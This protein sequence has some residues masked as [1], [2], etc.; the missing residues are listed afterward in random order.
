MA[1]YGFHDAAR[2][3]P[4]EEVTIRAY[5]AMK[6]PDAQRGLHPCGQLVKVAAKVVTVPKHLSQLAFHLS[7][8]GVAKGGFS[9]DILACAAAASTPGR[10]RPLGAWQDLSEVA[11]AKAKAALAAGLKGVLDGMP[12]KLDEDLSILEDGASGKLLTAVRYRVDRKKLLKAAIDALGGASVAKA[13]RLHLSFKQDLS[14]VKAEQAASLAQ[15]HANL[16]EDARAAAAWRE[17]LDL[18]P[19]RIDAQ[20]AMGLHLLQQ[21]QAGQAKE[22]FMAALAMT[23]KGTNP[24][25]WAKAACNLADA[26]QQSG[27]AFLSVGLY[28]QARARPRSVI[29]GL[30][31]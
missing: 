4:N 15:W 29:H 10:A 1:T 5:S 3:N 20:T 13:P 31:P 11:K 24:G 12:T 21:G 28:Q 6:P 19:K 16:G 14:R 23:D 22:H 26:T 17:A 2:P 25:Q 30:S 27:E 18:D 8:A 9:D 7:A